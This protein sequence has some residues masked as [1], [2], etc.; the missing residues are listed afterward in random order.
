[1]RSVEADD[2]VEIVRS[3]SSVNTPIVSSRDLRAECE[4]RKLD[5]GRANGWLLLKA[6]E[7]ELAADA[8]RVTKWKSA[9]SV[10]GWS[11]SAAESTVIYEAAERFAKKS[12]WMRAGKRR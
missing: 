2:L 4:R 11:L 3:L 12:G 6:E 10:A 9:N 5:S 7:Q 8:P 1:M